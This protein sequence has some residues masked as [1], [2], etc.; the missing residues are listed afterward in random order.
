M[1][2]F[3]RGELSDTGLRFLRPTRTRNLLRPIDIWRCAIV[4]KPTNE[5]RQSDLTAENLLWLPETNRRFTF[6]ADPF[7]VWEMGKLYVFV[8]RFDYRTLK[9]EIEVLVFDRALNFLRSDV[10]LARPWHLSYPIV[11]RDEAQICIL[12]EA[13]RSGELVIYRANSFPLS[14][15]ATKVLEVPGTALDSTPFVHKGRWWLLYALVSKGGNRACALHVAFA[16]RPAGPFHPHPLNPVRTGP[17]GT[18]PAGTP[19]VGED[20]VINVPV[21]DNSQTYGGAVR[22]LKIFRLDEGHFEAEDEIWLE[23]SAALSPFD[24]GL[25]TVSS[26]GDISLIDCK[27]INRS[28]S[29]TLA[30]RRGKFARRKR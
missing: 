10:V 18:R 13:N 4:K 23:P 26:A 2:L 1:P 20:G 25:H 22:R 6:R 21:Q 30:G 9:G 24:R 27:L 12:P 5:L 3:T 28:I 11:L 17:Q 8:E 14:W 15:E 7:G 19:F 16:D 29:G